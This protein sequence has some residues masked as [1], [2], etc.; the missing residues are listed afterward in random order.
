MSI[1]YDIDIQLNLHW[2]VTKAAERLIAVAG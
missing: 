2:R 1:I